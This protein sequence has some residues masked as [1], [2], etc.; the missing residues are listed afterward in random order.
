[1]KVKPVGSIG[2]WILEK[3]DAWAI[4]MPWQ[5]VYCLPE[6][7]GNVALIKHEQAHIDQIKRMGAVKFTLVYLWYQIKYG[8]DNNP[9]EIEARTHETRSL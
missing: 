7:I 5:T 6:H 1:M 2:R 3:L 4:T 9:L 8:Y